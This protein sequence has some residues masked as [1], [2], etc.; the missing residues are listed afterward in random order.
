MVWFF[1]IILFFHFLELIIEL[2]FAWK[3]LSV[4]IYCWSYQIKL[5]VWCARPLLGVSASIPFV[6]TRCHTYD[7]TIIFLIYFYFLFS[8][9]FLKKRE[10][11][12][13]G[14]HVWKSTLLFIENLRNIAHRKYTNSHVKDLCMK[15]PSVSNE[16]LQSTWS[17]LVY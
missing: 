1:Q 10:K 5:K 15:K 11:N 3:I 16:E 7:R 6:A 17:S 13:I 9:I 14:F 2:S 12:L 4:T 8:Y